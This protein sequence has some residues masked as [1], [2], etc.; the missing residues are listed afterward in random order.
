MVLVFSNPTF[1]ILEASVT[2]KGGSRR[3]GKSRKVLMMM[4][5]AKLGWPGAGAGK[6]MAGPGAGQEQGWGRSRVGAGRQ[7]QSRSRAVGGQE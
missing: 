1:F 7:E 3:A 2:I 5:A 6:Y 4:K